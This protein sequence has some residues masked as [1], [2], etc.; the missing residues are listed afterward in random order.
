MTGYTRSNDAVGA[1]AEPRHVPDWVIL[2]IACLGRSSW[3]CSTFRS[4][5]W[6]C[7]RSGVSLHYSP[8]GLQWVVNAYVLTFAGSCCS[9]ESCRHV[10]P[11][12]DRLLGFL[13]FHPGEPGRRVRP[14]LHVAHRG[15]GG[16]GRRGGVLSPA[17]L[18]I[19]VTTFNGARIPRPSASGA[20]SQGPAV[21][22]VPSSAGCS[23]PRLR[24]AGCCS[25]TS[26]SARHP[27]GRLRT[28][29]SE[30]RQDANTSPGST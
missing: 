12:P 5:T 24:G 27:G 26:R 19:V 21:R 17:T 20:R 7:P 6:R 29:L 14:E 9:G 30:S 8:T 13:P 3:W 10:R 16:P 18:T 22:P 2:A 28:L 25:S 23:P 1:A 11:A 15:P 4:S